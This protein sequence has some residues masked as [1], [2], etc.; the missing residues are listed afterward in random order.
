MNVVVER[1]IKEKTETGKG[2][3][4]KGKESAVARSGADRK[5][6]FTLSSFQIAFSTTDQVLV[7]VISSI[8]ILNCKVPNK[9]LV[10]SLINSNY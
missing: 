8:S 9:L 10:L 3:G 1:V 5:R 4:G 7:L 6:A 2:G